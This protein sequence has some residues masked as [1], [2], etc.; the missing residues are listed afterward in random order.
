MGGDSLAKNVYSELEDLDYKGFG[1]W[2]SAL[3]KISDA[4]QLDL[5]LHPSKF[6]QQC[7]TYCT[8][9]IHKKWTSDIA[10]TSKHPILRTY[11][12]WSKINAIAVLYPSLD[13][14]RISWMW[15][16]AI[17]QTPNSTRRKAVQ[18]VQLCRWWIALCYFMCDEFQGK[19]NTLWYVDGQIS[20]F[21]TFGWCWKICILV[22]FWWCSN[23]VVAW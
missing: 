1:T 23:V 9:T 14:A 18:H 3:H 4:L 7:Q 8:I 6:R 5:H 20:R 12:K 21:W 2:V 15:K 17:Y 13:T 16:G 19:E 22:H 10:D 11:I